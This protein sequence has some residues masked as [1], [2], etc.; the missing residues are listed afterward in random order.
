[1]TNTAALGV[2]TFGRDV[3]YGTNPIS[4]AVSADEET[5]T[6]VAHF[7]GA[8]RIDMFRDIEAFKK[9]MDCM[10]RELRIARPAEGADRVYY[11][12]LKEKLNEIE[13]MKSGI[14]LYKKVWASVTVF[15]E[16]KRIPIPQFLS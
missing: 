9:Y 15:G 2:P 13:S 11:A 6:R 4:I 5:S 7:F 1:M 8:M 14:S 3:M 12:G 10:L 16:K